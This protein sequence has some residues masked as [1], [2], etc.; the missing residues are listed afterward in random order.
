MVD[1]ILTPELQRRVISLCYVLVVR[2]RRSNRSKLW[3]L[4]ADELGPSGTLDERYQALIARRRAAFKAFEAR[5][6]AGT[7]PL[8]LQEHPAVDLEHFQEK[9][10]HLHVDLRHRWTP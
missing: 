7:D 2:D 9:F 4:I 3:Q 6:G 10:A 1:R 5:P 8:E